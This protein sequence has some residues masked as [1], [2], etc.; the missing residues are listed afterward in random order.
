MVTTDWRLRDHSSFWIRALR[1]IN[2]YRNL[3]G[4][5]TLSKG[6]FS[7]MLLYIS[8]LRR[9]PVN[10]FCLERPRLRTPW[11]FALLEARRYSQSTLPALCIHYCLVVDDFV[12]VIGHVDVA[13]VWVIDD[14]NDE[15]EITGCGCCQ[16]VELAFVCDAPSAGERGMIRAGAG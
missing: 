13:E 10:V 8:F 3:G 11:P 1:V 2:N 6:I 12:Y 5:D 9:P 16:N 7:A 4:G 14:R 15:F